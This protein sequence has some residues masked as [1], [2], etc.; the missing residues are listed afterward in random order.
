[1]TKLSEHNIEDVIRIFNQ[2]FAQTEQTRL[3]RGEDEPLYI[4]ASNGCSYHRVVFAHGFYRSAL[5]E[6]AHWCIAGKVR[7]QLLDYGYWYKP[8]GRD[9]AE[10]VN[11]EQV[12]SKPQALEW[13]FCLNAGHSFEVSCDNLGAADPNAIDRLA[14][15]RQVRAQLLSFVDGGVPPR[16]AIFARALRNYYGLPDPLLVTLAGGKLNKGKLNKG[17]QFCQQNTRSMQYV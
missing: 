10:Q 13:L 8:D 6:I 17:E 1:M 4:P 5:H 9:A 16:A 2:C 15:A 12:E 3:L 7:R 11:F 14:F